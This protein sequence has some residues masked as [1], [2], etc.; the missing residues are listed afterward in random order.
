MTNMGVFKVSNL[1]L[2]GAGV[3]LL[4]LSTTPQRVV[5]ETAGDLLCQKSPHNSQCVKQGTSAPSP[6][7]YAATAKANLRVVPVEQDWRSPKSE[8][9][10]SEPVIVRDQFDG[11]YLAVFDKSHSGSAFWSGRESGVVTQWTPT[12]IAVFAYKK[13]SSCGF[14]TCKNIM[15]SSLVGKSL[16]IKLGSE[17]FKL[18][19]EDSTFAVT[20]ELAKALQ[21]APAEEVVMRITLAGNGSTITNKIGKGTVQA[22]K[23]VY[24]AGEPTR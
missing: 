17:I 5:A 18:D 23:T 1:A 10:W 13:T 22:W 14:L 2:F 11:E 12:K 16:E 9:P 3:G 4:L 8:I 19:G 20:P 6:T 15:D 7:S 24:Q 21:S